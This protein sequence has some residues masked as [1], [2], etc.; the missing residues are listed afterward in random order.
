MRP[1]SSIIVVV[2]VQQWQRRGIRFIGE[3]RAAAAYFGKNWNRSR[4]FF[5][6]SDGYGILKKKTF[7]V[8]ILVINFF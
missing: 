7:R 1:W 2:V 8:Y 6:F 4:H 3:E 5:C